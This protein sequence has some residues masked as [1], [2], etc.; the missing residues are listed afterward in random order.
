MN[1][2]RR[3]KKKGCL[4]LCSK[5]SLASLVLTRHCLLNNT[6]SRNAIIAMIAII[7]LISIIAI[8]AQRSK[9]VYVFEDMFHRLQCQ[10]TQTISQTKLLFFLPRFDH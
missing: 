8:I 7:S 10:H 5:H 6:Y 1:K 9:T 4:L 3:K 2:Q